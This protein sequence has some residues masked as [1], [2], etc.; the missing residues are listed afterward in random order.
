MIGQ[1]YTTPH[2]PREDFKLKMGG[3]INDIIINETSFTGK[4]KSIT[5]PDR[6]EELRASSVWEKYISDD[7]KFQRYFYSKL[8]KGVVSAYGG[9]TTN[10]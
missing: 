5:L 2:T 4:V 3:I 9:Y 8:D 1:Y 10:T 7:Y 6:M